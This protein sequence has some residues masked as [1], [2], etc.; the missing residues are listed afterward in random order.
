MAHC[1]RRDRGKEVEVLAYGVNI[2]QKP[3]NDI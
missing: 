1:V 3:L 2:I